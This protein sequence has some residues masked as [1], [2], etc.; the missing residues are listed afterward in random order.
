MWALK[1]ELGQVVHARSDAEGG[2]GAVGRRAVGREGAGRR[3]RKGEGRGS[4]AGLPGRP[5]QEE[6]EKRGPG[7]I[8]ELG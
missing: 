6:K 2:R 5:S 4:A 1:A 8:L 7:Q 3:G